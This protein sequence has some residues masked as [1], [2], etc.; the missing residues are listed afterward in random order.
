MSEY[1]VEGLI[2]T[3]ALAYLIRAGYVAFYKDRE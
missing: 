2:G 1:L 3:A